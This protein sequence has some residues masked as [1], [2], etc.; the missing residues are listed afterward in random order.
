MMIKYRRHAKY[1]IALLLLC[2]WLPTQVLAK[3]I[4]VDY[5]ITG[6]QDPALKNA[7]AAIA[8]STQTLLGYN[9]TPDAAALQRL[10]TQNVHTLYVALQPFGYFSPSIHYTVNKSKFPWRVQYQINPGPTLRIDTLRVAVTGP[11]QDDPAFTHLLDKFP[12]KSG[13]VFT[14]ESYTKARELLFDTANN[15]GYLQAKLEE[16]R[17]DINLRTYTCS[18]TLTLST[19]KRFYYGPVSFSHSALSNSFLQRYVDFSTGDPFSSSQVLALQQ[20]LSSAGYFQQVSVQPQVAHADN[21]HVPILVNLVPSKLNRYILSGGYGTDTGYRA[22]VGWQWR[23][24]NSQGHYL[25]TQVDVSQIGNSWTTSYNIPGANPIT[26]LYSISANVA[27]YQTTAGDSNLQSYGFQYSNTKDSW[28]STA[29]LSYQYEKYT[30]TSTNTQQSAHLLMP[31]VTW[32]YLFSD[33]PLHPTRGVRFSTNI[34]GAAEMLVSDTDFAQTQIQLNA[35][36][37]LNHDNRFLL[38]N[39]VGATTTDNYDQLPL[40]LRFTAGGAQS[41][42]GYG[43]QSLGP[44]QFLLVN[45]VEYQY[46]VHGNWFAG[47]FNDNGNAFDQWNAPMLQSAAGIAGIWQ[48]PLGVMELSIARSTTQ[49]SLGL[50]VQFSMGRLL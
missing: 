45:S 34:R 44:A 18:I 49:P 40:S 16:H 36:M 30:V 14:A 28:Q 41:V 48:S 46:R 22:G 13:D 1:L 3:Q 24:I 37:P 20:N 6:V 10:I 43:Y 11:G 31:S 19:G 33:D 26:E 47:I 5:T 35:L 8:A 32:M 42:R 25:S 12:L 4:W 17:V 50:A 27:S 2:L 9:A 15:N 21:Q 39:E 38:R 23:R 29:G 7:Q